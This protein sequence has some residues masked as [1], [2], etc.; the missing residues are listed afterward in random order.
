MRTQAIVIA[1]LLGFAL[2]AEP[3]LKQKLGQAKKLAQVQQDADCGDIT[4]TAEAL[5]DFI[6][7]DP[8]LSWCD[9]AADV[10]PGLG[11]GV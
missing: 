9:C 5:P 8:D 6:V 3:T 10:P 7:A 4:A 1:A 2:A 11:A